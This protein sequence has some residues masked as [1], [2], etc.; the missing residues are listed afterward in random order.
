M[1][2]LDELRELKAMLDGGH[3][4]SRS[5][6]EAVHRCFPDSGTLRAPRYTSWIQCAGALAKRLEIEVPAD[7]VEGEDLR[8]EVACRR[9]LSFVTGK[10]IERVEGVGDTYE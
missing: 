10:M 5:V 3:V 8:E 2:T 9:A 7:L 6:D 1:A 4:A